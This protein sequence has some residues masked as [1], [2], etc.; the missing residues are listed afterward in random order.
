MTM[1]TLTTLVTEVVRWS[2]LQLR[3]WTDGLLSGYATDRD[4]IRL[5]R[6]SLF[7]EV[8]AWFVCA[9]FTFTALF[10]QPWYIAPALLA[11]AC[12]TMMQQVASACA[13][14]LDRRGRK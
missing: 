5:R 7:Y 1:M 3:R 2:R 12:G 13:V 9:T 8:L 14:E 11:A 4:V 10:D 6:V